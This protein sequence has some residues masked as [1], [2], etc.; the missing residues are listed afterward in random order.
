MNLKTPVLLSTL[1][2]GAAIP[3]QEGSAVFEVTFQSTWSRST[4]PTSFPSNPHYS[5]LIGGTHNG[6]VTFWEPGGLAT[7]GIESMAETGSTFALRG[8]ITSAINAGTAHGIVSGGGL[9]SPASLTIR[10]TAQ[11]SHPQLTMTSMLAPSPD[12]FVGLN[13]FDLMQNGRWIDSA[14][15]PATLWDAGTDSGV[16][17]TSRNADTNPQQP[18]AV[19]S[20]GPFQSSPTTVGNWSIRRVASAG[21][22]GCGVNPAGSLTV[23]G[24]PL[25]GQT[26]QL[27]IDD[28]TNSM[29]TGA[30]SFLLLSSSAANGFPCGVQIPGFGMAAGGNGEYLIGSVFATLAGPA[31]NGS[32]AMFN[33]RIPNDTTLV[34]VGVWVQ[35]GLAAS[36][37]LGL[38][39]AAEIYIGQ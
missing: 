39:D 38:A 4:H 9:G 7:A 24:E 37:R 16:S 34:G 23:A 2:L 13:G 31:W 21:V 12:W 36:T 5:P 33:L 27:R 29:S 15:V 8:E 30:Q 25:L 10:F 35:G 28:P 17:Y 6:Q 20:G 32:P 11:A 19:V 26:F 22:Y 18:I 1:L 3:A 14:S